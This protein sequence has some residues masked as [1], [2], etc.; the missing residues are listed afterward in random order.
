MPWALT[1]LGSC[2]AEH[3]CVC[4]RNWRIQQ[5]FPVEIWLKITVEQGGIFWVDFSLTGTATLVRFPAMSHISSSALPPPRNHQ[6]PHEVFG[7]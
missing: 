4:C 2:S 3:G 5:D 6:A 7:R 1:S